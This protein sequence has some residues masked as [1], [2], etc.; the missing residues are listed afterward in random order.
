MTRFPNKESE[1]YFFVTYKKNTKV[2]EYP[3]SSDY[4]KAI[5]LL[6][7]KSELLFKRFETDSKG[8][9]HLHAVVRFIKG[10]YI[11]SMLIQG[12]STKFLPVYDMDHLKEYL[13]KQCETDDQEASLVLENYFRENYAFD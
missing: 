2:G 6:T 3:Q 4:D 10:P 9:L 8:R 1:T 12:Y 13:F 5:D 7:R 11:R